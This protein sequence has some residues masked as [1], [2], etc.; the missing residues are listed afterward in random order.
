MW[1]RRLFSMLSLCHLTL[2]LSKT[3]LESSPLK[4]APPTDLPNHKPASSPPL[5][6]FPHHSG[7]EGVGKTALAQGINHAPVTHF[8]LRQ[9]VGK[10]LYTLTSPTPVSLRAT[11]SCSQ[12]RRTRP[13]E[14]RLS[15]TVCG[16]PLV[17]VRHIV[18]WKGRWEIN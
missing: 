17:P 13:R 9:R 5:P 1:I 12:S 11:V 15:S 10:E 18:V 2:P 7:N 6:P 8:Q 3:K 16:P 4:P 14:N